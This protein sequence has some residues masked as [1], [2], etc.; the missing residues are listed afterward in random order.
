MYRG[1]VF[2]QIFLADLLQAAW[3]AGYPPL[4]L[5][6]PAIDAYGYDIA[7]S[8]GTVVR[9]VQL[10][11]VSTDGRITVHRGLADKPSACVV[12]L[13][14]SVTANE[15]PTVTFLYDYFGPERPGS[16]L[17]LEGLRAARK[18]NNVVRPDGTVMKP[19]SQSAVIG[20]TARTAP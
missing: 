10:K 17:S 2:E 9:H 1:L 14:A 8:C 18:T 7:V 6:R 11:A 12:N 16:P 4:E 13:V 20:T 19:D 3:R 15:R 5:D